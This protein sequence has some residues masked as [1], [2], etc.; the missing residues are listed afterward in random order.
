MIAT[1]QDAALVAAMAAQALEDAELIQGAGL[2]ETEARA[3]W[4]LE[5]TDVRYL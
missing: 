1:Q 4:D 2:S 3:L 5:V